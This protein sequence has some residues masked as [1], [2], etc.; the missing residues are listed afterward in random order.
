[1]F[2]E[3]ARVKH[4]DVHT[5]AGHAQGIGVVR[6]GA[7]QAGVDLGFGGFPGLRV[8]APVTGGASPGL[9]GIQLRVEVAAHTRLY[10]GVRLGRRQ[11][12]DNG[13]GEV[14]NTGGIAPAVAEQPAAVVIQ[15]RGVVQRAFGIAEHGANGEVFRLQ[16]VVLL[17]SRI[18]FAGLCGKVLGG[19]VDDIGVGKPQVFIHVGIGA[20]RGNGFPEGRLQHWRGVGVGVIRPGHGTL[21]QP[22]GQAECDG[23]QRY[24]FEVCSALAFLRQ[25][26]AITCCVHFPFP[27]EMCFVNER[28]IGLFVIGRITRK[29]NAGS[30]IRCRIKAIVFRRVTQF[31]YS[32]RR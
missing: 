16:L 29:T 11:V 18:E 14:E 6:V 9:A 1:M 4:A 30:S 12:G 8:G 28:C 25:S 19:Q 20:K 27:L 17:E 23:A 5:L 3:D 22:Q 2:S 7:I 24:R 31:S 21:A 10:V 26:E 32:F 13:L 15:A